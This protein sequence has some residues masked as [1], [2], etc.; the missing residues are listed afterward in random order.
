VADGAPLALGGAQ[1]RAL[2]A[3]LVTH[4]GETL[5]TD[6]LVDELWGERTPPTAVKTVQVYI[7]QLRKLLGPERV[8]RNGHGYR[9]V[10]D[11][12]EVDARRFEARAAE[13]RAALAAGKTEAAVSALAAADAVWRGPALA[14]IDLP[15]ALA[16]A[17]RLED[18]RIAAREDRIDAELALGRHAALTAELEALCREHPLRERLTAQR[19]LALYRAGRQAEALE[20]YRLMRA[21][22]VDELGLEPGPQLREL[23]RA[24]LV[25]DAALAA[26]PRVLRPVERRRLRA[27]VLSLAAAGVLATAIAVGR[28]GDA[29]APPG[30]NTAVAVDPASLHVV[31][32]VK[33][34]DAPSAVAVTAGGAWV[35]NGNDETV[36]FVEAGRGEVARTIATRGTPLDVA[37]GAGAVW[38]VNRPSELVGIDPQAAQVSRRLRLA[39]PPR[40]APASQATRAWIAAVDDE[41]WVTDG[42]WL[43]RV[44]PAARDPVTRGAAPLPGPVAAA[45]SVWV[46]GLAEVDRRTLR[47]RPRVG[48]GR[49]VQ[50]LAVGA[51]AVWIADGGTGRVLRVDPRTGRIT[52]NEDVGGF[53]T[54][55]AVGEGAVWVSVRSGELVRLDR[56]SG[57]VTGR[58]AVGGSPTAVAAGEGLVWVAAG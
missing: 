58:V 43:W 16:E 26:P 27:L 30:P 40:L 47:A 45:T 46:G 48:V 13:G 29:L 25:H 17:A 20:V 6:R 36:S 41:V 54:G 35:V 8:V 4:A 21:R 44:R 11:A 2:L 31:R 52:R 56:R 23:E 18:A 28:G 15:W 57:A 14:E 12:D 51:G 50:D 3:L 37:A 19:M 5:T 24:I 34:G 53:P 22:L 55:V 10:A 9:L 7:S 39:R 49:G 1:Q 32:R 38:V 33:V 42:T